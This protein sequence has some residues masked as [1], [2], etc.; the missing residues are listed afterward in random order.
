MEGTPFFDA[1]DLGTASYE[2]V[3]AAQ[4]RLV[5]LRARDRDAP[6]RLLLVEHPPTIT[7]GRRRTSGD[8]VVAAGDTP[9]VQVE[10]GGDVTW[11][12]PGQLV[13]YPIFALRE[14]PER[15]LHGVLRRLEDALIA[16]LRDGVGLDAD[17]RPGFTGVW[18]RGR[19]LVS[20][21][22]AVS[23]WVTFHGF[24][25]NVDPDLAEFQR[26]NP[27]GLEAGVMG[28]I[29][30]LGAR[31]PARAE[32]IAA[33]VAAVGDAF[34]R[35]PRQRLVARPEDLAPDEVVTATPAGLDPTAAAQPWSERA[36]A[37]E[38]ASS[39]TRGLGAGGHGGA[40]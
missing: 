27:C 26:I 15:D 21:G 1:V 23:Q 2:A 35:A 37:A 32:L 7:L 28:S 33:I 30:S 12:G 8:N 16:V 20:I 40:Q 11:H 17:R 5:A 34:E 3:L 31:V 10:R 9:V 22:V 25:L 6:D 36:G 38:G 29:R 4:R 24:A 39:A 14:G 13:G 19:K 18:C